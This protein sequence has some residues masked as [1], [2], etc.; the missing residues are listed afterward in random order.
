MHRLA[1]EGKSLVL[2]DEH[3]RFKARMEGP[4]SGNITLRDQIDSKDHHGR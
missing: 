4:V 3:G 1:D 2:L